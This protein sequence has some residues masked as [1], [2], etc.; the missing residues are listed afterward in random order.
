MVFP[1]PPP[2]PPPY[3]PRSPLGGPQERV[4]EPTLRSV[5]TGASA[6]STADTEITRVAQH[7]TGDSQLL[8][9]P[10]ATGLDDE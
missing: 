9:M 2:P 3:L 5:M 10:W 8:S 1:T 6:P 4:R 7:D